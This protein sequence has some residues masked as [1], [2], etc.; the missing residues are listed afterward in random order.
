MYIYAN[1]FIISISVNSENT[2]IKETEYNFK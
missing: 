1:F 2:V